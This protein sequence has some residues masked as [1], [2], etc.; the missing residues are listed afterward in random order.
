MDG[1]WA[2]VVLSEAERLYHVDP[3]SASGPP[4]AAISAMRSARRMPTTEQAQQ[5]YPE[6]DPVHGFDHVQR[7]QAMAER[8][9]KQLGADLEILRAAALLHW[10]RLAPI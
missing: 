4:P 7:V 2:Q 3:Q 10:R 8:I 6:L 9:G 5:W 1:R